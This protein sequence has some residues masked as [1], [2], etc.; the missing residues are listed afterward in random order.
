MLNGDYVALTNYGKVI[1]KDKVYSFKD[2]EAVFESHYLGQGFESIEDLEEWLG[3]DGIFKRVNK[4]CVEEDMKDIKSKLETGMIVELRNGMRF[5]ILVN[6]VNGFGFVGIGQ[7]FTL[8]DSSY[9]PNLKNKVDNIL[10]IIKIISPKVLLPFDRYVDK[11]NE[12][13]I[14]NINLSDKEMELVK[15]KEKLS[16]LEDEVEKVV[17]EIKSKENK[18]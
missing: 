17:A 16:N 5:I 2:G 14:I 10:D 6:S 8:T 3:V 7:D 13:D 15:L 18:I 1:V 4:E 9:L 12:S 11:N